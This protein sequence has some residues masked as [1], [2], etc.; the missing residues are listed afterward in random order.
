MLASE[1]TYQP[2]FWEIQ[3]PFFSRLYGNQHREDYRCSYT[4]KEKSSEKVEC[5][6]ILENRTG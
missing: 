5:W 6:G 2:N 1:A 3:A 4:N